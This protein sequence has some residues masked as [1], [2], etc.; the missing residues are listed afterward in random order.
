M[1]R[2]FSTVNKCF[3]SSDFPILA[4]ETSGYNKTLYNHLRKKADR[5]AALNTEFMDLSQ[6]AGESDLNKLN[7]MRKQI[8]NNSQQVKLYQEFRDLFS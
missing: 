4:S 1:K 5:D 8:A 3:F 7:E 6:K 2:L